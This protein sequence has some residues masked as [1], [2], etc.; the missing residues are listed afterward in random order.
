LPLIVASLVLIGC[1]T[2]ASVVQ[3]FLIAILIS[4][5][6]KEPGHAW[7]QRGFGALMRWMRFGPDHPLK[8]VIS[9]AVLAVVLRLF[10]EV[11]AMG[12]R[13]LS[14]HI[15]YNGLVRVRCDLFRKLQEM[16]LGYHRSQPQGDAIYRLSYDT[17]GFQTILTVLVNNVLV[18]AATLLFMAV[19]MVQMNWQL[20]LITLSVAPLLLWVTRLFSG[21]LKRRWLEAKETDSQLTTAI[22]RSVASI[23]LVQA[24][25]RE[26]DEFDRFHSSIQDSVRANIRQAWQD[27]YYWLTVGTIF[28]LGYACIFGYGGWMIFHGRLL[29]AELVPFLF[30]VNQVYA[31]LQAISGSGASIQGGVAGAQRVFEVLDRD[32]IIKDAPDA[33]HLPRR[34]RTLTL[35]S[36]GFEYR[37]GDPVLRDIDATIVP[38]TMVAFVGSS[39][40]GKTTLLNL[41]PRF[42]DPTS[43]QLL[44]DDIDIRKVKV[45]DLRAHVALVLQDNLILPTTVAENIAYGRPVASAAQI[46]EAARLA[47]AAAF[48]DKM[49]EKYETAVSE[50]GGNLSG[51]QRQRI[52]IA[53]AVLTE[54]PIM[55]FDEPTSA[56]DAQ[57]EA[58]IIQTLAALKRQRTIILVSH[59]LTTVADCDEIFVMDEGQIVERG[60]HAQLLARRGLYYSMANQI[61]RQDAGAATL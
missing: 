9:L 20:A 37:P 60:T 5:C 2:L 11:L 48:I 6:T 33:V 12:Q 35:R 14:V 3:P 58:L 42:Y 47:G 16:S 19:L 32:V 45:R 29:L 25:G 26:A 52:G 53:R 7:V 44:L 34:P 43:G 30:F 56:L 38:G 40:V 1:S 59:R 31:P 18:G 51:G 36:V 28:G 10:Q 22:Q 8:Q 24:F 46:H 61:L 4:I 13:L 41:L 57:N 55:V 21:P 23:G 49:P 50:S 27:S 39:G 54:A 17:M 15:G